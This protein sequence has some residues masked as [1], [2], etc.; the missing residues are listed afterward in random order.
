MASEHH[1]VGAPFPLRGVL[2]HL[3]KG[4]CITSAEKVAEPMR[5]SVFVDHSFAACIIS[6]LP[7][8]QR[9]RKIKLRIGNFQGF[10]LSSK[11]RIAARRT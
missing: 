4:S 8:S 11:I 7:R 2:Y 9:N 3:C 1:A 6:A 10:S 5:V